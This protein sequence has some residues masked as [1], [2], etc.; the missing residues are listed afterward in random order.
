MKTMPCPWC[1]IGIAEDSLRDEPLD[2]R[3]GLGEND[4]VHL[5][6]HNVPVWSCLHC[7]ME[8]TDYRGEE[9]REQTI[10]AYDRKLEEA[11]EAYK[12]KVVEP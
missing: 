7:G 11:V 3:I 2:L 12:R 6:A 10:E 9:I 4:L 1:D 5:T 8:W